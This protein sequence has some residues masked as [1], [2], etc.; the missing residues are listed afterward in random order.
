MLRAISLLKSPSTTCVSLITA[1]ILL[2]F[3]GYD[4]KTTV[5]YKDGKVTDLQIKGE[6]FEGKAFGTDAF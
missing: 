6:N 4:I 3:G 5:T 1:L 2:K